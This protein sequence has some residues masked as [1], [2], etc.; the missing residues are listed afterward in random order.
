MA[1]WI[2]LLSPSGEV[3]ELFLTFYSATILAASATD[4]V[5]G[6]DL[7]VSQT[8]TIVSDDP[9][10]YLAFVVDAVSLLSTPRSRRFVCDRRLVTATTSFQVITWYMPRHAAASSENR[11]QTVSDGVVVP[12]VRSSGFYWD[13]YDR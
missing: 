3:A 13:I 5:A 1:A 11:A 10:A 4:L 7:S 2:Y 9:A 12:D 8:F 6:G